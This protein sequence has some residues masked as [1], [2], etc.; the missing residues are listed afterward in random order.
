MAQSTIN[1]Y[2]SKAQLIQPLQP[3]SHNSGSIYFGIQVERL[4]SDYNKYNMLLALNY[5]DYTIVPIMSLLTLSRGFT[6][7]KVEFFPSITAT[8]GR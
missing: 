3:N 6:N 8:I 4:I 5:T 1:P 2:S 7:P